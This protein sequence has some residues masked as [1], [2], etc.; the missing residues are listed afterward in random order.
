DRFAMTRDQNDQIFG[1]WIEHFDAMALKTM[2]H[3][4]CKLLPKSAEA[5]TAWQLDERADAGLPQ[6]FSVDVPIELQQTGAFDDAADTTPDIPQPKRQS[7][8]KT[9]SKPQAESGELVGN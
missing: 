4:V 7:E 9:G 5:Q 8:Q 2:I 1:V 3:R 6:K